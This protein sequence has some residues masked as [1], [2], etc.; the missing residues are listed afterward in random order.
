MNET[1]IQSTRYTPKARARNT[2]TRRRKIRKTHIVYSLLTVA[3]ALGWVM[4]DKGLVNP[5]EGLGYWLGITGASMMVLLLLYPLRKRIPIMRGL[6]PIRHWFAIHMMLGVIG[7]TLILYHCNFQLGSFNSRVALFSMLIV[8]GSG[9]IGRH[10]YARIHRG[11]YGRKT[12]LTELQAD[13]AASLEK[14]CGMAMIMP[15]LISTLELLSEELKGDE[16]TQSLGIRQ[17]L[18]WSVKQFSVR[19][20]LNG[21]AKRELRL[22]AT[23]S[24][25]VAR[26]FSKLRRRTRIYVRDYVGLMGR[27]AQ[28]SFYERLF[29][30]W[31]VLHLPLFFMLVLSAIVHVLAVHMY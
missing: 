16:I 30:Y 20:K 25:V 14:S 9:L 24:S 1:V 17:S 4:R 11:L 8:S 10:F 23:T 15:N 31:H 12:S 18:R 22:K 5:E 21:I 29:S 26:D 2:P 6:A 13:L 3:L 7:P 27:V 19:F 28:F